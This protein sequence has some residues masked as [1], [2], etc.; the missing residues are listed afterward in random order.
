MDYTDLEGDYLIAYSDVLKYG[1]QLYP[2]NG[3]DSA[4][5]VV[6]GSQCYTYWKK[7]SRRKQE[8]KEL[9]NFFHLDS[10]GKTGGRIA[11][12]LVEEVLVLPY[13]NSYW[14]PKYRG[15]AKSGKHWHYSYCDSR[16]N[17]LGIEVDIKSAYISSL[18][19]QYSLL[20]K[21]GIGYIDD[22]GALENLKL[23]TPDLPKWFRLQLLGLLSSWRFTFLARDKSNSNGSE[24][25]LKHYYKIS[26]NA[27]FNAVH[28]AIL[29]NYKIMQKI[30]QIGGQYIRRM[31]TDSF[32][33]DID[34]PREIEDSI[35]KYI[36]ERN[37]KWDIKGCGR[38]YFFDLNTGFI[39]NKFVG[40]PI[41]VAGMM[42]EEKI[43]IDRKSLVPQVLDRFGNV[44]ET[45]TFQERE[46]QKDNSVETLNYR[47]LELAMI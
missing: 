21:E 16:Q 3:K 2:G 44:I 45:S 22:N 11:R 26:Y 12:W 34:C 5:V 42:R 37:L 43:K 40:A 27:A 18:F 9:C 15:I 7:D 32:F 8:V 14:H 29:R 13:Q 1:G 38:C 28:R 31:H 39:G 33:L 25:K 47:Q 19:S 17:F 20:Y 36:E 24:L 23:L 35:W 4:A 6:R 10:Y 30:H 41:D 46:N